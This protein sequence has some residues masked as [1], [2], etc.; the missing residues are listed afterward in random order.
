MIGATI[1][2]RLFPGVDALVVLELQAGAL[3]GIKGIVRFCAL[4]T[5]N[6]ARCFR[7]CENGHNLT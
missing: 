6:R 3:V 4:S 5:T 7:L 1:N 2:A